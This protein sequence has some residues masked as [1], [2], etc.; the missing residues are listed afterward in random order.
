M[1]YYCIII[2]FY[3]KVFRLAK[4][5]EMMKKMINEEYDYNDETLNY[6]MH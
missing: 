2:T 3:D 1:R 5:K 6:K 4:K